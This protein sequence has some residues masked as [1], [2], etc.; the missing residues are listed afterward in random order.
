[1]SSSSSRQRKQRPTPVPTTCH[2]DAPPRSSRSIL[3]ARRPV[4][5]S[6]NE[7]PDWYQ[8]NDSIRH[9]YRPEFNSARACFA[10]WFY[11][12]NEI[13]NIYTHLLPAVFFLLAEALMDHWV[14]VR[15][16]KATIG[17]RLIFA[18]FLLSAATCLG[19]SA[20]YH[21]LMNHSMRVSDL[22]LRLDFVGIIV[23]T[24]GDFVSGIYMVFYCEPTLRKIYWT[25]VC[26]TTF[27]CTW[28]LNTTSDPYVGGGVNIHI[29]EPEISRPPFPDFPR[30]YL[31]LYRTVWTCAT[32]PRSDAFRRFAD[33]EAVR[34]A[35]LPGSGPRVVA[36]SA[37]LHCKF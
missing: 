12:H 37:L 9:G 1:M 2:A 17:D 24:L 36:G 16:S 8:D 15:Y 4:L 13:I 18:F 14:Q 26:Q 20:I 33:D 29:S 22:W 7:I 30:Q 27:C 5:L 32:H 6:Y 21:T 10:S 34:N 35:V 25:M 23:L 19:L 11:M 31:C 3:S 28:T